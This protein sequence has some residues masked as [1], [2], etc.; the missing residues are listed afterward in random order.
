MASLLIL[1][2]VAASVALTVSSCEPGDAPRE[3]AAEPALLAF[4]TTRLRIVSG[5][6]TSVLRVEV[7]ATEEQRA[8]GLM[9]RRSLP[10]DAGM[11]FRYEQPQPPDAAFWMFRTRIPLDIAFVDSTG[12]IRAI[13]SMDPCGSPYPE[14]C[15]TYPA[16]VP[17]QTALEVNRGSFARHG[18][19]VGDRLL[20]PELNR[21]PSPR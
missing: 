9:E 7:A 18:I 16:G 17:F 1:P 5:A 20:L 15:P 2:I 19:Q 21:L 3:D 11:L 6:D 14:W 8:L 13:R 12:T 4:D 10:E